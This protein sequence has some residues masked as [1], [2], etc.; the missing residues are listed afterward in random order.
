MI[1]SYMVILPYFISYQFDDQKYTL[2]RTASARG[3]TR[4]SLKYKVARI[5]YEC[6]YETLQD[7]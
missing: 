7:L 5:E 1:L 4:H 3:T 6:L 2:D